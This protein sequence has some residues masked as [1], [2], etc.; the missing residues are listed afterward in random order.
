MSEESLKWECAFPTWTHSCSVFL[1][2]Q[3]YIT[4]TESAEI[5]LLAPELCHVIRIQLQVNFDLQNL[6]HVEKTCKLKFFFR[7]CSQ[8]N[9]N[10]LVILFILNCLF[11]DDTDVV[12]LG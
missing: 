9:D 8:F 11:V 2:L 1:H 3:R 4:K 7:G 12:N 10:I 5:C 6:I